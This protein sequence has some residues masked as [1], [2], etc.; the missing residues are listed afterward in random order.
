MKLKA[1]IL[2]LLI[3]L[4]TIALTTLAQEKHHYFTTSDGV[5]LH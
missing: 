2:T 1:H 5:R 3:S 4:L